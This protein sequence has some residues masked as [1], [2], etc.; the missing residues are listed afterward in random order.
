M[1][2]TN[3]ELSIIADKLGID[4]YELVDLANKHPRVNILQPGPGVG[5]HCIAVDPW[6][7]VDQFPEEAKLI[8]TARE[9]NRK[10][11]DYVVE[12]VV[13]KAAKFNKPV[14]AC[15]GLAYK[16]DIDDLRESPSVEIYNKLKQKNIGE[17]LACEPNIPE[18]L[19]KK[20]GIINHNLAK[21]LKEADIIVLLVGRFHNNISISFRLL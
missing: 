13:R 4:V 6:F 2:R 21:V 12:K 15:L 17:V 9:V 16:A 11:P 19:H 10:K 14:I 1:H 8:K 7:I 3:N 20:T 18:G 5:G